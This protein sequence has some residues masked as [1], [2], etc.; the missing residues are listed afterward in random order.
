MILESEKSYQKL[1]YRRQYV[2]TSDPTYQRPDWIKKELA[3]GQFLLHHS[4]L[5][6]VV[7]HTK[8]VK[9]TLLGYLLDPNHPT[10]SDDVILG[11]IAE[12]C[13]SLQDVMEFVSGCGGRFVLIIQ[14][15]GGNRLFTDPAGFRQI[16]YSHSS[17]D[18]WCASQPHLLAEALNLP[19]DRSEAIVGFLN[20][21][22]YTSGRTEHAWYGD[23]TRF[24]GVRHLMPNHYLDIDS[25]AIV[26]F[27]PYRALIPKN[28]D[29][30]ATEKLRRFCRA[31]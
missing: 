13:K 18:L 11:R 30:A 9:M 7:H 19:E 1:L 24:D 16:Y 31:S 6:V 12:V 14:G 22:A 27:W 8:T 10:D 3:R 2:I 28:V 20:S 21:S 17:T 26:R 29:D 4:D 5:N 23:A 25:G 15:L